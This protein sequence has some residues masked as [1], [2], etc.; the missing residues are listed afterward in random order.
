VRLKVYFKNFDNVAVDPLNIILTIY[1]SNKEVIETINIDESN[2]ESIGVYYY[3]YVA[4]SNEG[5]FYFEYT[6]TVN[7]KPI[8][9]RK[10][11]ETNFA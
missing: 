11:I 2:K 9:A 6:G 5:D 7:A 8:V 4:P 1:D 10:K 3:D